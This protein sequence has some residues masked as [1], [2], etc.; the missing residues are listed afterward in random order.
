MPVTQEMILNYE[1]ALANLKKYKKLELELRN[2]IIGQ[3]RFK[4][5]EGLQKREFNDGDFNAAIRV[6]LKITRKL[7]K[8]E[9]ESIW[10]TLT[11]D[12]RA[13][14]DFR[15]SLNTKGYKELDD[16]GGIDNLYDAIV[17]KPAQASLTVSVAE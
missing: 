7:D 14:I 13:V 2:E 8:D 11:G 1:G 15:P 9:V 3:Q 17:E 16:S 10:D 5:S 6:T 4:E 12:E